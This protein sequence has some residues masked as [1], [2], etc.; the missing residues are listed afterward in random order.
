MCVSVCVF[1][2]CWQ[3]RGD[4]RAADNKAK[5]IPP[6]LVTL[7]GRQTNLRRLLHL[8][9][10]LNSDMNTR[11]NVNR[12]LKTKGLPPMMKAGR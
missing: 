11:V 1:L 7:S 9:L 10:D 8:S 2:L 4:D 3:D 6:A 5:W 12:C